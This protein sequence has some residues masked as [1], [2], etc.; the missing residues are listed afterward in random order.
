MRWRHW[1]MGM[2]ALLMMTGCPSG[3]GKD[4]RIAKAVH[5]DTLELVRK[6]CSPEEEQRYC[7]AGKEHSQECRD[8]CG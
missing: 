5:Q 6:R 4:G 3:Y 2:V 7:G 1:E 8:K